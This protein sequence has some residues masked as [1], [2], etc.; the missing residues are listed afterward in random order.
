MDQG[1]SILERLARVARKALGGEPPAARDAG[2]G[3]R[4]VGLSLVKNEEDV[5]EPFVRHN[6]RFL[7]AMFVADNGSADR[8]REILVA[9][10]REGLPLVVFDDPVTAYNQSEKMTALLRGVC[11]ATL[12]DYV[13]PLDADEFIRSSPAAFREE[14]ARIPPGG[15]GLVPWSTY[16][17][18]PDDVSGAISDPPRSLAW[19]RRAELP[20]YRKVILRLDGR[21]ASNIVL[22]Q[23]NHSAERDDG[24]A[25]AAVPLDGLALAHF[26]VRSESQLTSKAVVGWMAYLARD[27]D[28]RRSS[29][30][31]QWRDNFDAALA[32][33]GIPRSELPERSLMYAQDARPIEWSTD[34]V[35]DPLDFTY[36]RRYGSGQREP[37]LATIARSWERA[38]CPPPSIGDGL[39]QAIA[40][41][42]AELGSGGDTKEAAVANTAFEPL[43]HLRHP[44]VDIPPYRYLAERHQPRSVLDVGCGLG[45][46]LLVFKA[47]GAER[48]R[49]IDGF[50]GR[51]SLLG[52]QEYRQHDLGRPFDLH[53]TF[54][55]VTCIEVAEHLVPGSEETLMTSLARHA[56]DAILFSAAEKEQPGEAHINC[57]PFDEW[58]ERWLAMG[59]APDPLASLAF[60]SLSTFSWL[61]RNPVLLRRT[62]GRRRASELAASRLR[63]IGSLGFRWYSQEPAIHDHAFGEDP[64][65]DL[66]VDAAM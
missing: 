64:P 43:W 53:E 40:Q 3:L 39:R 35:R 61:R 19:R 45:A 1:E 63:A 49:G 2:H 28:A 44:F 52:E 4:V 38:L 42:V 29:L 46:A 22:A 36:V 60:R 56:T 62:G 33:G 51:F 30:G 26:P 10:E 27:R 55:L 12:P 48:V 5:I 18:S 59:W 54:D 24:A 16:V 41:K 8:T 9:M 11:A 31:F 20:Q 7:D 66:Y 25:L 17:V 47:L 50:P 58:L 23:G 14:L 37:A 32:R 21:Y 6:L 34:I 65:R 13:V 15:V 57:R